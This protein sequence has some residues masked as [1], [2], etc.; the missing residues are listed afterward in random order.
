MLTKVVGPTKTITASSSSQTVTVVTFDSIVGNYQ[1]ISGAHLPA[2]KVRIASTQN[3]FIALNSTTD[4]T[5]L[6][7]ANTAEHFKLDSSNSV[8][9]LQAASGGLVTITPVA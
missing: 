2:L 5:M 4:A 8:K 1:N 3:I 9:I 7:P 6:L